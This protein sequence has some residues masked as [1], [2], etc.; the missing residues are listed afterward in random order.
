VLHEPVRGTVRSAYKGQGSK[1]DACLKNLC[2]SEEKHGK[3]KIWIHRICD[4]GGFMRKS[5]L[6]LIL[7]LMLILGLLSSCASAPTRVSST[8]APDP[9]SGVA[10]VFV[11]RSEQFA[12]SLNDFN[13]F[14]DGSKV[15]SVENGQEARLEVSNGNHT[16]QV[17]PKIPLMLSSRVL[18]FTANTNVIRFLVETGAFGV[19]LTAASGTATTENS[20][21]AS[22]EQS[23]NVEGSLENAAN[24]IMSK[25]ETGSRI[26][27]VYVTAADTEISEYIS[28]ELEFIMIEQDFLLID[29]SQLDRIRR[30]QNFQMSGE[31]DDEQAVSVGKIAGAD[32]IIT[33]AV[34]G[35]GDL[36]RLRLRALDTQTGQV[37]TAASEK[38]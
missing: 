35:T 36:R 11:E 26:A 2:Q 19:K 32:I 8:A 25:L 37:L 29:R 13:I 15:T 14:I 21:T 16:I 18:N 27:I 4:V 34:T 3:Q 7:I 20:R 24:T 10:F 6:Y 22:V 23:S 30:E 33:G 28:N 9:G 38:Y 1:I 12:G 31:V 17:K 5:C